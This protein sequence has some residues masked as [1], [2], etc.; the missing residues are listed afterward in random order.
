MDSK[1]TT[2][3]KPENDI[4]RLPQDYVTPR[5]LEEFE[6]QY[7]K[8]QLLTNKITNDKQ[9]VLCKAVSGTLFGGFAMFHAFRV[10][11]LWSFYPA[12]EKVFNLVALGLLLALSGASFNAAYEI[13][14][15]QTMQHIE[16]RPPI[17]RRL[18]GQMDYISP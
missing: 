4:T 5:L 11:N 3:T 7:R 9:C 8:E 15:G 16:M 10:K 12:R 13:H 1:N 14:M 2:T 18:T 6:S 17:W